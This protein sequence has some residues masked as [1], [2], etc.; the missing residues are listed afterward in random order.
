M[1]NLT[2]F[3]VD[4]GSDIGMGHLMRSLV[5]AKRFDEIIYISKSDKKKFVPY[6]LVTIQNEEEFFEYV[7]KL[8][9]IQV[10]VDNYNF[11]L[12]DEKK[13]K[14]R[15]PHIKLSVFDDDYR[16]H[17]CDEIIN[18]NISADISKY[19]NPDIV[20][21]IPPL[22]REEFHKEKAIQREKIYDVFVAMGGTD[23]ANLNVAILKALPKSFKIAL[24]TTSA[25][26]HLQELKEFVQN[27][28]N[29]TLHIDSNEIAKVMN[30][31]KLAIITPSVILHEVLFMELPFIAI[32]TAPNQN[33]I[34]NYLKKRGYP[35]LQKF[36][37]TPFLEEF[38]RQI[39]NRLLLLDFREL[40]DKER[41]MVL[42]WRNDP[43]IRKWMR[44]RQPISLKEHQRFIASLQRSEEKRYFV[45]KESEEY[46]GVVDFTD[47]NRNQ[48]SAFFGV[49][50]NPT[51]KK[52]GLGSKLLASLINYAKEELG[53][54]LLRLEVLK[55]NEKAIALYKKFGF[56]EYKQEAEYIYMELRL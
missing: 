8:H 2:L 55:S 33:E 12:E 27:R 44:N 19:P 22:I 50:A 6:E 40:S 43:E 17:H 24:V 5:Y 39:A 42:E 36:E 4:F 1:S 9:P 16:E 54:K 31:S 29:V 15:F 23:A 34:A 28:S 47:I 53:L 7:K 10:V 37:R 51:S 48:K 18:H 26:V 52:R 32:Q 38:W 30:Q 41:T 35:L 25:N 21:I 20:T 3:R 56:I 14:K 46:I 13:F 49:Y 11:T 45:V